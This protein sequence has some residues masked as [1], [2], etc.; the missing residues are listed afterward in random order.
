MGRHHTDDARAQI[1][2]APGSHGSAYF[3]TLPNR[4]EQHIQISLPAQQLH[5]ASRHA[6]DQIAVKGGYHMQG[7]ALRQHHGMLAAYLKFLAM[8]DQCHDES[9][10]RDILFLACAVLVYDGGGDAI[11]SRRNTERVAVIAASSPNPTAGAP[12]L[13]LK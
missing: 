8:L 2:C 11:A 10:H 13:Q 6:A 9:E 12:P 4:H 7:I 3:R 5:P 1:Q